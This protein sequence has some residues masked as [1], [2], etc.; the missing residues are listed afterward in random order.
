M[1]ALLVINAESS[2]APKP[3]TGTVTSAPPVAPPPTTVCMKVG[4]AYVV[5]L[6]RNSAQMSLSLFSWAR[7]MLCSP[8]TDSASHMKVVS[9]EK[10]PPTMSICALLTTLHVIM[11]FG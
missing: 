2:G 4:T 6:G 8:H 10:V 11:L 3:D 1:T 7:F 5:R 9:L